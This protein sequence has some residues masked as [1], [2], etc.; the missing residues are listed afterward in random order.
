MKAPLEITT[1]RLLLRRPQHSDVPQIFARY[2]SDAAVTR[3][4]SWP[5][6]QSLQQTHEF[7]AL[8]DSEWARSPAGP[9]LIEARHSGLLLG[10]TGFMFSAADQAQTGYVLAQDAWHAGYATEALSGLL[11][12]CVPLGI[13]RVWAWCHRDHRA[14]QH[15]LEK[16]HL[17]REDG[18][19]SSL[20]FPNLENSAPQPVLQYS[21][22]FSPQSQSA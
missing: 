16:C 22:L 11:T 4:L 8:S 12:L 3:Y 21:R 9:F 18:P 1:Q 20:A 5:R 6:H 7:L 19:L 2:A 13:R 10:G 17:Q 15:V 14:S